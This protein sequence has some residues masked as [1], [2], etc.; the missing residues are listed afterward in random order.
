MPTDVTRLEEVIGYSFC[1]KELLTQALTHSSF[2]NEKKMGRLRDYER[3][4]FLGDAVLELITSKTLY[5][6]FPQMRE[7]EMTK[8]R[9]NLVCEEALFACAEA[10]GLK[11][12]LLL[13]KGEASQGGNEKPSILADVMEAIAGAIYI[14][15][16]I[17]AAAAFIERHILQDVE[18][19]LTVHDAKTTLQE[20]VQGKNI[21]HLSYQLL[22]EEGP[23]HEKVFTCAVE[24]DGVTLGTGSGRNKKSAE[25]AAA[26]QALLTLE[27]ETEAVCI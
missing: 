3:L 20:K 2:A 12:Y 11:H 24:L 10:I 14:D 27:E 9:A 19:T 26:R 5:E 22:S 4:E 1:D 16:G 25:Q 23:E 21:G 18:H 6:H 17:D 7:G 15:G 8:R 13:G